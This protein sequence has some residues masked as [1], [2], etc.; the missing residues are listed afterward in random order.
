[1]LP[2]KD[3]YKTAYELVEKEIIRNKRAFSKKMIN[4]LN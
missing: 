4:N 1:M 2:Y 3:D